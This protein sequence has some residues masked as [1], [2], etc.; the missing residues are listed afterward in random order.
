MEYGDCMNHRQTIFLARWFEFRDDPAAILRSPQL[1]VDGK[2]GTPQGAGAPIPCKKCRGNAPDGEF[3]VNIYSGRENPTICVACQAYRRHREPQ[4]KSRAKAKDAA[5]Q[6]KN[7][8]GAG[9]S[10]VA[11]Q[12]VNN[13]QLL[14][15]NQAFDNSQFG[16]NN[17]TFD[18]SQMNYNNQIFD[19]SQ[20]SYNNHP[21]DYSPVNYNNQAFGGS[22]VV[23]NNHGFDYTQALGSAQF[24]GNS[25]AIDAGQFAEQSLFAST[26]E[27]IDPSL[28]PQYDQAASD[29]QS[30]NLDWS[31]DDS[32]AADG[33]P[34]SIVAYNASTNNDASMQVMGGEE[35]FSQ[36]VAD[37]DHED[38]EDPV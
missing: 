27:N 38:H 37:E 10:M 2:I 34:G 23:D 22:Q 13:S 32:Q 12:A 30:L 15:S 25:Q 26:D 20:M 14:A 5:V 36:N 4:R 16:Y 18:N 1:V 21:F 24:V 19:N 6:N 28:L 7:S 29:G 33:G 35:N 9:Q 31:V 3:R 8:S 11:N 17:Q